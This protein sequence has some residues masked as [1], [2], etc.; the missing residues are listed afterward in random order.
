MTTNKVKSSYYLTHIYS[1]KKLHVSF[2]ISWAFYFKLTLT[3]NNIIKKVRSR[4]CFWCFRAV[5][6]LWF[7]I[8][9]GKLFKQSKKRFYNVNIFFYFINKC[10]MFILFRDECEYCWIFGETFESHNERN[11]RRNS[12]TCHAFWIDNEA[13]SACAWKSFNTQSRFN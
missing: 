10:V 1:D 7:L 3:T 8:E 9:D 13:F 11:E 4:Q 2:E 12:Q 5:F 6:K